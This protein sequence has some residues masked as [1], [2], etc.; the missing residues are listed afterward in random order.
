MADLQSSIDTQQTRA[1]KGSP[2]KLLVL[3]VG[4]LGF[5]VLCLAAALGWIGEAGDEDLILGLVGTAFFLAL[6][7]LVFLRLVR[8]SASVI[9]LSPEGI[10]DHR[11]TK[12]RVAWH[13]VTEIAIWTH[14]GGRFIQLGLETPTELQ[15]MKSP[16][17]RSLRLANKALGFSGI[18]I[19]AG[20]LEIETDELAALCDAYWRANR[21]S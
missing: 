17:A 2:A 11:V 6:A 15:L 8:A 7:V 4:S 13:D 12:Q 14:L 20:G 16:L 19:S 3:F 10:W 9:E 18:A 1:I 21:N 5:A